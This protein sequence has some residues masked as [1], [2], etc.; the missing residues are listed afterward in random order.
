MY[1]LL[2]FDYGSERMAQKMGFFDNF[3][4]NSVIYV[5]TETCVI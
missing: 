3:Y 4:K 5:V 1:D 2:I